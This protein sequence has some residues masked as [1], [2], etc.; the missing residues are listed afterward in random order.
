MDAAQALKDAALKHGKALAKE[1]IEAILFE[2]IEEAVKNTSTPFD[3]MAVAALKEP[4]KQALLAAL[5]KAV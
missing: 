3:D 1:V 5:D 4:L 2:A